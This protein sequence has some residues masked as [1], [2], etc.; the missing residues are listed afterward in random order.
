MLVGD[1][2][3]L[4]ELRLGLVSFGN[5]PRSPELLGL[6]RVGD[7]RLPEREFIVI[8]NVEKFLSAII[9]KRIWHVDSISINNL[10]INQLSSEIQRQHFS[11]TRPKR[12]MPTDVFLSHWRSDSLG[13]NNHMRAR[14]LCDALLL[15]GH[16]GQGDECVKVAFFFV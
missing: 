15:C 8:L 3:R 6:L 1:F 14:K 7:L 5:F 4:P 10:N 16:G 13:R 11:N 12:A 2:L 9:S